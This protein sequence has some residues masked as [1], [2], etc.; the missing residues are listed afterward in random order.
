MENLRFETFNNVKHIPLRIYNRAVMANNVL[1]DYGAAQLEQYLEQF[2]R[3]EKSQIYFM[4][5]F[6]KSHGAKAAKSYVLKD[7]VPEEADGYESE[8]D[9]GAG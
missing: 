7:F 5:M 2:K 3:H 4:N 6:I 9:Q 1:A 8:S